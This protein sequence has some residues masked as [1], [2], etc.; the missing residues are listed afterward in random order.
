[1][2]K[3][4]IRTFGCQMNVYDSE[5]MAGL[6]LDRDYKITEDMNRADVIL[7][8]TCAI[9]QKAED[10]V[11]S[12]LG[13]LRRLKEKRPDLILGVGGCMAQREGEEIFK[14]S[15]SVDLIF[16][17]HQICNLPTILN[18]VIREGRKVIAIEEGK[19]EQEGSNTYRKDKRKA[20][21]AIMRGCDNHC[22]YCVVPSARGRQRS[23]LPEKIIKEIENLA[24][25]GYKEITLLGQ[26]V[27]AY[28]KDLGGIDFPDLLERING[29]EGIE[30]I[31]Y[32]SSHPKD[33]SNKL[34]ETLP[35]LSK[36]CEDLHLPVQSGSNGI[37][38]AMNRG[39][40]R[41]EYLEIIEKVRSLIPKMSITTDIIVG[42]PGERE[43]DFQDTLEL[44]K[45]IR[46]NSAYMFQYSSRPGT[47]A[48]RM[49]E[50][51]PAEIK[52]ERLHKVISLQR[53]ISK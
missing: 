9:R 51:I 3:V 37:L 26:N 41:E 2:K 39:Y 42:F 10:K 34:I 46:F 23:R 53:A 25:E 27:A 30:K 21:V 24:E 43:E 33:I 31:K 7:L 4:Y 29:I 17:T 12:Q 22:T 48:E 16:G 1:M 52:L 19:V 20:Y 38:K 50:Q 44:M 13:V 6:L 18:E 47:P 14:R 11:Y 15:P 35:E 36:V 40:T 45:E 8:N 28:G 49:P 32:I 5:I